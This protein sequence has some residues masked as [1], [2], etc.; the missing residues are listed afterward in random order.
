MTPALRHWWLLPAFLFLF[1]GST[2][3]ERL[4]TW[5]DESSYV[6]LGARAVRGEHDLFGDESPGHRV[7]LAYWL[8][9]LTQLGGPSLWAARFVSLLVA[10][11]VV[12]LVGHVASRLAGPAAGMVASALLVGHGVT[13]GYLVTGIYYGWSHVILLGALALWLRGDRQR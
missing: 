5:S 11:G 12:V 9:G 6:H 2:L 4:V 10:C 1:A 7:P 8:A 13:V 3:M